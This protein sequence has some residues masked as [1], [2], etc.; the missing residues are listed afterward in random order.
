MK[1]FRILAPILLGSMLAAAQERGPFGGMSPGHSASPTLRADTAI[2]HLD[3]GVLQYA[4]TFVNPSDTVLYLDCQ[5]PP[6]STLSGGTLVLTFDRAARGSA[7]SA[8]GRHGGT[9]GG[10]LEGGA[11]DPKDFPPQRIGP[12]QTFQ[13]QRKLDRVLGD[14]HDRPKFSNVQL[15]MAYYPENDIGE[16]S[17]FSADEERRAVA[18]PIPAAQ[19]GKAP[20][21]AK[22]GKSKVP[23]P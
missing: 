21:A 14:Y 9:A 5:V 4:F 18:K 22:P 19:K 11:V 10:P 1:T 13:G 12:R 17:R 7:D 16:E 6:K 2:Y 15:R 20:K 8:G 23:G 3:N